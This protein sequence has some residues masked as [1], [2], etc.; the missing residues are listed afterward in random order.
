MPGPFAALNAAA[1]GSTHS[2]APS[3]AIPLANGP[4]ANNAGS[5]PH[6]WRQ[7]CVRQIVFG[8]GAAVVGLCVG[9]IVAA[10]YYLL[11]LEEA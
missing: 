11:L 4:E 8:G 1:A 9:T 7:I 2:S 3:T 10:I 6:Q 5:G